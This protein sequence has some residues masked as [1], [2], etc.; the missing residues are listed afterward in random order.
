VRKDHV[1]VAGLLVARGADARARDLDGWTP[2]HW[3]VYGGSAGSVKLLIT[4]GADVNA[5]ENRGFTPLRFAREGRGEP[6]AAKAI[7]EAL[8]ASGAKE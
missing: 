5:K 2:L 8:R 6:S 4:R 1:K 3:A 7:V